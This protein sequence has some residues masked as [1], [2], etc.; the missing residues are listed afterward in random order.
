[1]ISSSSF[2]VVFK[3][4]TSI[5]EQSKDFKI[6]NKI[7]KSYSVDNLIGLISLL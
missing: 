1:M 2:L 6:F 7:S 3:G 5:I 4:A